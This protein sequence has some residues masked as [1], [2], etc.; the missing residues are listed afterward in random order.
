M[1]VAVLNVYA[2]R[3]Q[4]IDA[5]FVPPDPD[6]MRGYSIHEEAGGRYV[7]G[8]L[9]KQW[10]QAFARTHVS[11]SREALREALLHQIARDY[12]AKYHCRLP[13]RF[14]Y[15]V[16]EVGTSEAELEAALAVLEEAISLTPSSSSDAHEESVDPNEEEQPEGFFFIIEI[17]GCQAEWCTHSVEVNITL[18]ELLD[19]ARSSERVKK[20]TE[21]EGLSAM[22]L[23]YLIRE[24]GEAHLDDHEHDFE[25]SFDG[26]DQLRAM[27]QAILDDRTKS[28][29]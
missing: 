8:L 22:V 16:F 26:E 12:A 9:T 24:R 29:L 6:A 3:L 15:R 19:W 21:L 20:G 25:L 5:S 14:T 10:L 11:A 4:A 27:A 13:A 28:R 23:D 18:A 7:H 1:L 17:T 2:E